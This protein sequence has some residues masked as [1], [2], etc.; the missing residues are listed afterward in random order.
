MLHLTSDPGNAGQNLVL[1]YFEE[2]EEPSR[3]SDEFV[4][5]AEVVVDR[6]TGVGTKGIQLNGENCD[7]RFVVEPNMETDI[8]P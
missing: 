1:R 4:T 2:G 7:G 3:V 6:P 8:V 5:G